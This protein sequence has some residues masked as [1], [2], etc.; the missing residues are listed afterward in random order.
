MITANVAYEQTLAL[1]EE[2]AKALDARLD[3]YL[4]NNVEARIKEAIERRQMGCEICIPESL[5]IHTDKIADKIQQY[6]FTTMTTHGAENYICIR[7][8][9]D[10]EDEKNKK[11]A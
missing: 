10:N 3:R 5:K 6:G 1:I 9:H 4:N 2:D 8:G 7:W 11:G